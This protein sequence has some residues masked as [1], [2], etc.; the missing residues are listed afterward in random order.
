MLA[1][2]KPRPSQPPENDISCVCPNQDW[3]VKAGPHFSVRVIDRLRFPG[4]LTSF[5]FD[6]K[7]FGE[8]AVIESTKVDIWIGSSQLDQF[9]LV[10]P[11]VPAIHL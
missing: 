9:A 6:V 7:E 2:E 1:C 4:V 11:E 3:F 10:Q 5:D 8:F